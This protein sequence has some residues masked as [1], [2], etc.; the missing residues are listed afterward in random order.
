MTESQTTIDLI[1]MGLNRP[2]KMKMRKHR[3]IVLQQAQM[4]VMGQ[5]P[6]VAEGA[7]TCGCARQ[8]QADELASRAHVDCNAYVFNSAGRPGRSQHWITYK[9][10][11]HPRGESTDPRTRWA[12]NNFQAHEHSLAIATK[13]L[14]CSVTQSSLY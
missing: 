1:L 5:A 7:R 13:H 3:E 14:K 11:L 9:P 10:R 8:H 6:H 12:V 4:I 2:E